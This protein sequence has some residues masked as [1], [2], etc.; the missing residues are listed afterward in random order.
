MRFGFALFLLACSLLAAP[1]AA[2]LSLPQLPVPRPTTILDPV[3][4]EMLD[5]VKALERAALSEAQR[6]EK[7][8]I[9]R[10]TLLAKRNADIIEL[11][12]EGAPARR[13]VLLVLDASADQI[14]KA[15]S[16]GFRIDENGTIEELDLPYVQLD[17]PEGMSLAKAE[18]LLAQL[19]PGAS[20]SADNL[21]FASGSVVA[22]P[23]MAA[24]SASARTNTPVGVVDG[25]PGSA[26][27]VREIRGFA[28]GAPF[29][30]NHGSA[31]VW[32]LNHAG[33]T[34]IRV[35]DVYG[36]DKAGGNALAIAKAI[37]WLVGSGS[38]V[39]NISLVGPKN[40]LVAKAVSQSQAKG[41]V[42]VAAVGN[43]GPA[44]PPAYPASYPGVVSVTG[45]DRQNRS[46]IE[47]G[48]ALHLD[49]AA[50]GADIF[51]RNAKGQR[52]KLRGTSFASALVSARLAFTEPGM[53]RS[54]LDAE[55]VDLGKKGADA[56]Y[57]RGLLCAA[58]RP[59]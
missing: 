43:D 6:L 59:R 33:A 18:K 7:L 34:N 14:E 1:L 3:T 28:G 45:V 20:I 5:D 24:Q 17:I 41:V 22:A 27:P 46:L 50:P 11:D 32:L 19:M 39:I 51:G 29:P 16:A 30:S 40:A 21:H 36:T 35:A 15:R 9:E 38:K 53:W 10:I 48:R 26:L 8:R 37:G 2:Q 13:G 58:C 56:Q 54:Q 47:A 42:F 57:G 4:G 23:V 31:I 25:A 12:V 49:Y 55:A 44:A 52:M